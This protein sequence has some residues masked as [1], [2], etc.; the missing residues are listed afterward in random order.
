[1]RFHKIFAIL[2]PL[3]L[4]GVGLFVSCSDWDD[5]FDADT[6]VTDSQRSSILANIQQNADL[7]QFADLLE[8]TGYSSMLD[9][10]QTY[11]VWAPKNNS[12]DYD[13]LMA[14]SDDDVKRQFVENHI[15]RNNYPASG[16]VSERIYMLNKKV[17][18]FSSTAD[19]YA[20]QDVQLQLPSIGGNNGT[21]HLLD[22]KIPYLPNI[23]ESLNNKEFKIDSIADYFHAYDTLMLDENKSVKG[24]AVDGEI[25]YLDAIYTEQNDLYR[26]YHAYINREDSSYSMLVPTNTAWEKAKQRISPFFQYSKEL[27]IRNFIS[28]GTSWEKKDTIIKVADAARLQDSIAN[29]WLLNNLF[30]NNRL[31]DNGKLLSL[32][33][34]GTLTADSLVTTLGWIY[35][36]AASQQMFAGAQR[37]DKSNGT[38][39][40]VD[41]LIQPNWIGLCPPIKVEAEND[42]RLVCYENTEENRKPTRQRVTSANQNDLVKGTVSDGYYLNIPPY[43]NNSDQKVTFTL[44]NVRSAT[45]HAYAVV[46]PKHITDINHYIPVT[47][48]KPNRLRVYIG[49][50]NINATSKIL[51]IKEQQMRSVTD[52]AYFETDPTKIDTLDLGEVTFPMCYSGLGSYYPFI[53]IETNSRNTHDR[54]LRLDCIMLVPKDL[55]DFMGGELDDKILR[56]LW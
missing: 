52:K 25:T 4:G 29:T 23:Y 15:A 7:S 1:M 35:S 11:T 18:N 19:G 8:K 44:P 37:V 12:F 30:F 14:E 17:M 55:M 51:E 32:Q 34:G 54:T 45:Y 41:E 46:V 49:Y 9:Q 26:F 2:A 47:D 16:Q 36:A 50:S 10:A 3:T 31:Y 42:N 24:P 28:N 39:F 27:R 20:M 40:V 5:H 21:I 56:K 53:R 33:D 22:G 48:L 13:A 38:I 6:S 43:S